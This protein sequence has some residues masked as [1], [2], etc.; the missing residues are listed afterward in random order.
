MSK[1]VYTGEGTYN[2]D[3]FVA[4]YN[5]Y[6]PTP[7]P[8]EGTYK[9]HT[10]KVYNFSSN[11]YP[12]VL[13]I[14]MEIENGK[15]SALKGE[16]NDPATVITFNVKQENLINID[17]SCAL[18]TATGN[19]NV[20]IM[21]DDDKDEVFARLNYYD[22]APPAQTTTGTSNKNNLESPFMPKKSGRGILMPKKLGIM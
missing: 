2:P 9:F 21:H 19:I 8:G 6:L 15:N 11:N 20:I 3:T 10:N 14:F 18:I 12:N 22:A 16:T 17:A 1:A 7:K 4:T 5:V 13:L